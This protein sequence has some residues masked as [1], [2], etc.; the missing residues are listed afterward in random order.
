[1]SVVLKLVILFS[2]FFCHIVDDYYLQGILAQMKQ[3]GWWEEHAPASLYQNDYKMALVEHAFSWA[4]MMTLP[5]LAAGLLTSNVSL[6]RLALCSYIINT[7]V[8]AFIDDM[9]ANQQKINLMI[10]QSAHCA[11]IIAP[12][13]L[14]A[15]IM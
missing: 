15:A 2:M 6:L 12:G 11:Q 8:H 1:M 10:D 9:K 14:A 4:F 3:R 5:L 7:P 13:G